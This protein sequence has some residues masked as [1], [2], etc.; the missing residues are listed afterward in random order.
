MK[1]MQSKSHQLGTYEINKVYLILIKGDIHSMIGLKI[2][3]MN[4]TILIAF[5]DSKRE[6]RFWPD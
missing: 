5:I 1:G 3:H 6:I 4:I 2:N